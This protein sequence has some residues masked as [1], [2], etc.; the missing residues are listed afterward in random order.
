MPFLSISGKN[1]RNLDEY[2]IKPSPHVNIFL[3]KNGAGKTSL[4]E[5]IYLNAMGRSFRTSTTRSLIN[6]KEDS[7]WVFSLYE[8][9]KKTLDK[10]GI[11]R[12]K[13]NH[14]TLSINGAHHKSLSELAQIAPVLAIQPSETQLIDGASLIRRRH[15]DWVLFHVE[16]LFLDCWRNNQKHLKQRNMLLRSLSKK[17]KTSRSETIELSAWDNGF[18]ESCYALNNMREQIISPLNNMTQEIIS[19]FPAFF[20]DKNN[21]RVEITFFNGWAADKALQAILEDAVEQDIKK[22]FSGQGAHRC[23]LQIKVNKTLAKDHLSRGQKKLL[24]TALCLAQ[25]RLLLEKANKKTVVLLDDIFS[26]IDEENAQALIK[27]IE[28]LDTQVFL[29]SIQELDKIRSFF[30]KQSSVFHVEHGK[31]TALV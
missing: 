31:I 17:N 19:K 11:E 3:G 26:E 6:D 7:C 29:T 4:L 2:L 28:A 18:V 27:E 1:L 15:I 9:D 24:S 14:Q 8:N 30:S 21:T 22:G 10:I 13:G 5:G 12:K 16:P 25:A 20:N 23:D